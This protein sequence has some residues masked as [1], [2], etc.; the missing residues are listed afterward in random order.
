[1]AVKRTMAE[2]GLTGTV[3]LYGTP[4]EETVVGK[5][6]M[7]KA[8]LFD[9]LDASLDWH[10]SLETKVGN[11]S[12]QAM[13]NFEVEFFGQ[14]AHSAADPMERPLGPGCR[15]DD[16]LRGQHDAGTRPPHHPDPLRHSQRPGKPPTWCR[17]M[18]GSGTTSGIRPGPRW[19]PTTI[20]S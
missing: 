4:A 11:Q 1:M 7:A 9:D 18:P 10:P 13:N 3:R 14:A 8:G 15:G 17:N 5:V 19:M 20:G 2:H 6:Y 12:G 16:E